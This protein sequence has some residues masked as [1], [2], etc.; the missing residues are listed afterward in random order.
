[1]TLDLQIPHVPDRAGVQPDRFVL[2]LDEYHFTV[3]PDIDHRAPAPEGQLR[4]R[5]KRVLDRR[6]PL[7]RPLA[8]RF[9][10]PS[11]V[12]LICGIFPLIPGAGVFCVFSSAA[13]FICARAAAAPNRSFIF[14]LQ[15]LFQKIRRCIEKGILGAV[16]CAKAQLVAHLA[17]PQP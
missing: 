1:M 7:F 13:R 5:V 12:F 15:D 8:L 17:D 6:R 9:R 16:L 3:V 14:R 10:C 11:T 2:A 4:N